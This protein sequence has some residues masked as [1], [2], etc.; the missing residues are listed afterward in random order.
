MSGKS[1]ARRVRDNSVGVLKMERAIA[2]LTLACYRAY[3]PVLLDATLPSLTAGITDPLPPDLHAIVLTQAQWD[4]ILEGTFLPGLETLMAQRIVDRLEGE[5]V[6]VTE[7]Q[8]AVELGGI[9]VTPITPAAA[10]VAVVEAAY[11]APTVREA[12]VEYLSSVRNRMVNTPDSVFRSISEHL[13]EGMGKGEGIKDLR[14]RVQQFL[15]A[16]TGDWKG[17][18]ETVARTE[19]TGAFNGASQTASEVR[20]VMFG[21]TLEKVWV[22]TIDSRTRKTHFAADGQRRPLDGR[23]RIGKADLRFPG[24]PRGR[25]EEVINCRCTTIELE[26]DEGLP[27]E[28]DRQTER[29]EGNATV[30]NRVGQRVGDLQGEVDRRAQDE[31]VT[32]ARDDVDGEGFV[33][34]ATNQQEDSMKRRTWAGLLAPIGVPTGDGRIIKTGGVVEFRDF[35]Q[36][37][38]WQKVS[39]DGHLQSVVVGGITSA[40]VKG[41]A[42]KGVGFML[43][44]PEA[45]EAIALLE[46]GLIRPSIDP[47]D[48]VWEMV[49]EEGAVVTYDQLEQAWSEGNEIK[50]LDQFAEMRVMGATL[51]DHPAFAEAIITLDPEGEE[52]EV[53]AEGNPIE[54]EADTEDEVIV[55][56]EA[57]LLASIAATAT[58]RGLYVDDA[59]VF[60]DPQFDG[61]TG[62]HIDADGRVKGHL[63]IWGTCH[64]GSTDTCKQ[65]PTSD[66]GYAFFHVSEVGTPEGPLAVGKLTVGGGHAGP[67]M[68]LRAATE[69][70]DD[71]GS[72]FAIVRAGEDAHGIWVSGIANPTASA[73]VISDGLASPLS[74][75][76]RRAG[77]N[78]ELVAA[79]AVNT[80]GFPVPRG[81][82]D[83][84]GRE[85]SLVASGAVPPQRKKAGGESIGDMV[86]RA[87]A[88]AATSAVEQHVERT[89]T[90]ERV[91]LAM[92]RIRE[93]R[94]MKAAA[95][96]ARI[97]EGK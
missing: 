33:A 69:H 60:E 86:A 85:G 42:I 12:Q 82:R 50:V 57:A 37:L 41:D 31:G 46:E 87:A 39:A 29:G 32:R 83:D 96:A 20:Q 93:R 66:T 45:L 44:T 94:T 72:A 78:L 26:P 62:L 80:P 79:L 13:N 16:K 65:P 1:L 81:F 73:A 58:E 7:L 51:V 15:S 95:L 35:P 30:K 19:A 3:A 74:G 55:E 40:A 24:D 97:R 77:G 4:A 75:D 76:W 92:E 17:R 64:L 34:A 49:D 70:Y 22:A 52:P 56:A 18:A 91:R 43:D 27:D 2:D 67:R 6:D 23:F 47:A 11:A 21:I 25:A 90:V 63:A 71:T 14:G 36:P 68:G 61:P 88:L 38:S 84:A 48:V 59:A 5:G 10:G 89:A 9:P 53:D 8:K 28:A 54:P